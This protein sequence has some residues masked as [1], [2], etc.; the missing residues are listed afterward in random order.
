[1]LMFLILSMR[2]KYEVTFAVLVAYMLK[3]FHR[4]GNGRPPTLKAFHLSAKRQNAHIY[5]RFNL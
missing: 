2:K 5:D 4:V 3:A 1:M